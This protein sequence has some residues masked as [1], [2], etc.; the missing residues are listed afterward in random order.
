MNL[1][2]QSYKMPHLNGKTVH[3]D[4]DVL[5]P[6]N[7]TTSELRIMEHIKFMVTGQTLNRVRSTL[8]REETSQ[9]QKEPKQRERTSLKRIT[10]HMNMRSK[11]QHIEN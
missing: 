2:L 10:N 6:L 5:N 7:S 9:Q 4:P 1:R 8:R 3:Y 11:I